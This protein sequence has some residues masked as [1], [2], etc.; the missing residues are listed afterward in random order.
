MRLPDYMTRESTHR[1]N[2]LNT[3]SLLGISLVW[4]H[5]LGLISLWFLPLTILS[6]M[7]GYG[8]EIQPRNQHKSISL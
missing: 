6:I 7:A 2:S 1:T 8:N 4:G 3:L 5:M